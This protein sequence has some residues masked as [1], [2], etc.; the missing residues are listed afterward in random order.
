MTDKKILVVDDEEA[1]RNLFKAA[2][3]QK[4]YTVFCA[5][6]GE[7]A[8]EILDMESIPVM[9]LDINLP[10]MNGMDLCKKILEK[11][12]G[13]IAYAVTGHTSN[14]KSAE[15]KEAGFQDYFSKPIPIQ[16]LFDAA[17]D[18]FNRL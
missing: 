16:T 2:L 8:L 17:Q 6:S 7:E 13:T 3:M 9:F 5:E 10:G 15:C 14:R 4:K 11:T 12:P 18:A 1:I